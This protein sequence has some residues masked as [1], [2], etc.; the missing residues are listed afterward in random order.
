ME[1]QK[2]EKYRL[3]DSERLSYKKGDSL[4]LPAGTG[5]YKIEGCCDALITSIRENAGMVRI[6]INVTEHGTMIGLVDENNKLLAAD[7]AAAGGSD[8]T[9]EL[10]KA[11]G[12]AVNALLEKEKI[13]L[14]QCTGAGLA[15]PSGW[16]E[17]GKE[18]ADALA[19]YLPITTAD[20]SKTAVI[21]AANLI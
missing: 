10:A 5:D 20:D 15:L 3:R 18:A 12:K 19:V 11:A 21:G 16:E 9:E 13:G 8:T 14:D 7:V 6:G 1:S 4:F 17:K 2:P